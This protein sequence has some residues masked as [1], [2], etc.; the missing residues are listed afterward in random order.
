MKK[1]YKS[2]CVYT[3]VVELKKLYFL[4]KA[5]FKFN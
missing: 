3:K 2:N 1:T 4:P 5:I